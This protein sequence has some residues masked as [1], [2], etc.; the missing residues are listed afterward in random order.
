[1]RSAH[2]ADRAHEVAVEAQRALAAD[3]HVSPSLV[4]EHMR[5]DQARS[6]PVAQLDHRDEGS[7]FGLILGYDLHGHVGS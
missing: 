5:A 4:L 6:T 1:M 7:R 2:Q 3:L